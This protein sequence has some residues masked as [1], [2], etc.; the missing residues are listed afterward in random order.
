[1]RK[2][3]GR[4]MKVRSDG[5]TRSSGTVLS[6]LCVVVAL[7][8][9]ASISLPASPA[10]AIANTQRVSL[11]N[12]GAQSK[13]G[14]SD[15]PSNSANGRYI[16]FSSQANNLVVGDTNAVPD[17]F[18]RD[19]VAATTVRVSVGSAGAQGDG[20][21]DT[22]SISDDGRYVAFRSNS[23]NLVSGDTNSSDDI[24]V[25]DLIAG[26]TERVSVSTANAQAIGNS[27]Q[28]ALS[29]DGRFVV[30]QSLASNLIA[31]DLLGKADIFLRDRVAGTTE[32]VSLSFDQGSPAG[33]S[34]WPSISADGRYVA[35]SSFA[36]NIT[37]NSFTSVGGVYVRD[38]QTNTN[39]VMSIGFNNQPGN[40]D[41]SKPRISRDGSTVIWRSLATC[42]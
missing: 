15:T 4:E 25:R 41:A 3:E 16:A 20:T 5:T 10:F 11:T 33:P 12:A 29:A 31:N 7:S 18:V 17:V 24:F 13:G 19:T 23:S 28:P 35:F 9:L 39:L 34:Q 2:F 6:A 30:F 22:P 32:R 27:A 21:S 42:G 1:M 26:V 8:G 40:K 14:G 37:L 38:R 36:F